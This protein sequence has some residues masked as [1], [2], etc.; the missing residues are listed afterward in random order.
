MEEL[1]TAGVA[2][3]TI[4]D[5]DL[6]QPFGTVGTT[7]VLSIDE[8]VGKMRA[9]L[10]GRQDPAMVIAARTSAA[11][12][13]GLDD[14]IV[15][16]KAYQEVG[17]DAIFF[18][19]ITEEHQVKSLSS[20]LSVPIFLGGTGSGILGDRTFLAKNGV[21]ISLQGHHPFMATIQATYETLASL[22][23]GTSPAEMKGKAT[24]NFVEKV[25]RAGDYARWTVDYLGG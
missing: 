1:E 22:R 21:R 7:Q 18:T 23:D 4:E 16:G 15:R 17:V 6:P 20:A 8:G 2:A 14:A 19:G 13:N 25:T 12:I 24:K 11:T 5:T 3:L 9:A 10:S